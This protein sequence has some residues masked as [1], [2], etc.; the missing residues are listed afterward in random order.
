[1]IPMRTLSG[2]P[3]QGV[4]FMP[5]YSRAGKH[6]ASFAKCF[7]CLATFI[8]MAIM[9]FVSIPPLLI[10]NGG[11]ATEEAGFVNHF[12]TA[13]P[14]AVSRDKKK[15]MS[16]SEISA[17]FCASGIT[18]PT[19]LQTEYKGAPCADPVL[20]TLTISN[21]GA[22]T[23]NLSVSGLSRLSDENETRSGVVLKTLK[24]GPLRSLKRSSD[25]MAIGGGENNDEASP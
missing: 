11:H 5:R 21:P 2:D 17:F 18:P 19:A 25:P 22:D 10:L 23:V 6:Y 12:E 4:R 24:R 20:K 1:M 14:H 15:T 7:N 16:L 8:V 13:L 9:G 3:F